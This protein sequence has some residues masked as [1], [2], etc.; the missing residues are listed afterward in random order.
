MLNKD[1]E[2]GLAAGLR[3]IRLPHGRELA[4]GDPRPEHAAAT[5]GGAVAII[6]AT[7]DAE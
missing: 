3:T 2:V 7:A 6:E 4:A 5:I 1:L